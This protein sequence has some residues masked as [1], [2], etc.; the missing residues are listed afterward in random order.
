[1]SMHMKCKREKYEIKKWKYCA[2]TKLHL[3]SSLLYWK[4]LVECYI[5]VMSI[6]QIDTF[7]KSYGASKI[8]NTKCSKFWNASCKL[9]EK[10]PLW[11]WDQ[12]KNV[13]T[14]L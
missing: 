14:I 13:Q 3:N 11:C 1:M 8:Q 12:E 6:F 4:D 9:G 5:K 7:W 10:W 2:S